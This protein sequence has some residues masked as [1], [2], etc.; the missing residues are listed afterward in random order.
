MGGW[1]AGK[2]TTAV[3]GDKHKSVTAGCAGGH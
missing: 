1:G 2:A 3:A